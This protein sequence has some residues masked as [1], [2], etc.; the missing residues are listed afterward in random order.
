MRRG[1][2]PAYENQV[3]GTCLKSLRTQVDDVRIADEAEIPIRIGIP[4]MRRL[5]LHNLFLFALAHLFH[6]LYLIVGEP[7]NFFQS[8][9]LVVFGYLLVL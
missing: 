4:R 3:V 5:N 1:T 6:L 9:L 7:L 8:A 2:I